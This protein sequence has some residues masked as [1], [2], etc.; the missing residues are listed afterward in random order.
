M[1][2]MFSSGAKTMGGIEVNHK[3]V[4]KH[5]ATAALENVQAHDIDRFVDQV[6]EIYVNAEYNNEKTGQ[7]A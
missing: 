3:N 5:L 7:R 4:L 2:K 6:E 1:L